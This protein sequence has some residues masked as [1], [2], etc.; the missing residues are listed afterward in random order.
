[1]RKVF[2]PETIGSSKIVSHGQITSLE[3]GFSLPSNEGF[4]IYARPKSGVTISTPDI[5]LNTRC[6]ADDKSS[7][8]PVTLNEWNKLY[9]ES[10]SPDNKILESVDLYW[11]AG[12]A[13]TK[14]AGKYY[15]VPK[16]KSLRYLGEAQAL[17]T[18]GS[19]TG[20]IKYRLDGGAWSENVPTA[21]EVGTYRV[22]YKMD[23]ND[24][25]EACK[26][27][28][29]VCT[30]V[31]KIV[32]D[33]TIELTP[34]SFTYNG[35]P[36]IPSVVVKDG[37][38]VIPASEYSVEITNNVNA[39]T[40]SVVIKDNIAG[41]YEVLGSTTF[42][43]AKAVRTIS[44]TS[45]PSSVDVGNTVEVAAVVSAGGGNISYFSSDE[46]VATVDD[47][48]VTGVSAGTCNIIASIAANENFEGATAQYQISA[49]P[50]E[51][52]SAEYL[53]FIPVEDSTFSFSKAGLSYSTDNGSTWTAL[54]TGGTTPTV[55]AG[56]KI[57]WKN[58]TTLTPS[59][60]DGIGTF[61]SNKNFDVQGNIMSLYYGDNFVGQTSLSGK[62]YAFE[63]L[64]R[65]GKIRNANNLILPATTLATDCYNSMFRGCTSL[66]TAP[67]LPATTL[68]NDCC[69]SMF[70]E[71]TSLTT[72]P[73]LPAT[74]LAQYCYN[75]MFY[76]CTSL[77]TAPELPATT[78]DVQCYFNMFRGC[79][80][81]TTAPE[82]PATT[83]TTNCYNNMFNGC[84]HLN[85][86]KMLATNI[87]ASGCFTNWLSNVAAIGTF[88]KAE[89]V[90]IPSGA[91][92]IPDG[93]TVETYTPSN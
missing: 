30:I 48:V 69:N 76:G 66:T 16:A 36:C 37:Q 73:E 26:G 15:T 13:I 35:E 38:R 58:N 62:G 92:G 34:S 40:A 85:Y 11:G 21:T 82:L 50:N 51:D 3:N 8:I 42:N 2:I 20:T 1:M 10:I 24:L 17:V 53:T 22:D 65:N 79:T 77:T 67:E 46:N 78:L 64:F 12:C 71:C 89:G 44:F 54:D 55:A 28:T 72:A 83:L 75:N 41:N 47:N 7:D 32:N 63:V 87:S 39:G 59:S 81:L 91:S 31:E 4:T 33:P 70:R 80:S 88:V 93:W 27:G 68:A 29:V 5:I 90:T 18:A 14:G 86:V 57:L 6:M 56:S 84:T 19:G 49:V 45:A 23:G 9:L 43:I 60:S 74:T 25:Y 61:S 52:Y